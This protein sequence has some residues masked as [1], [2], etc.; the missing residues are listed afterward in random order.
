MKKR[1]PLWQE[2]GREYTVYAIFLALM[3][4]YAWWRTQDRYKNSGLFEQGQL[5]LRLKEPA[6]V[7][8]PVLPQN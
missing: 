3:M 6:F 8:D 1:K 7:V 4:G 2:L 5:K